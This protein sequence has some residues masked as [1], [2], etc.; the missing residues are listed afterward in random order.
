VQG[1]VPALALRARHRTDLQQPELEQGLARVQAPEPVLHQTDLQ[2]REPEPAL[3]RVPALE[4]GLHRKDLRRPE[5]GPALELVLRQTDPQQEPQASARAQ[6]SLRQTDRQRA[7]AT[8]L[9]QREPQAQ[10]AR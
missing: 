6:A 1:L 7:E 5:Q 2:R 4:P 10:P 8:V 3:E 9:V